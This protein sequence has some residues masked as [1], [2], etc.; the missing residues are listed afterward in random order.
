MYLYSY[1]LN[2][3]N[4]L[5]ITGTLIP[6]GAIGVVLGGLIL[7]KRGPGLTQ[8]AGVFF[9]ATVVSCCLFGSMF[10]VGSCPTMPLAGVSTSYYAS[11]R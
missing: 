8:T 6:A 7:K 4:I 11:N 10:T 2:Q 9:V 1:E 5:P 3:C